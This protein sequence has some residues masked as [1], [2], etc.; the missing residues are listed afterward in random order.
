MAKR[1]NIHPTRIFKAE[2]DL[3]KA[4]SEYKEDLKA[5]EKDW[6]KTHFVGKDGNEAKERRKLPLIMDGFEVFCLDRYGNVEQYFRNK[7]GYYEDFVGICSRIKKEIRT[8]QITG[9]MLGDFN[10]SITQ[11]LNGL[12]DKQEVT[13][14]T[15]TIEGLPENID[16]LLEDG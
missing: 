5:K 8:Q 4:W 16:K 11:R 2:E 14:N 15:I 9:G 12:T 6:E 1:G 13:Q 3:A 7:D 10:P